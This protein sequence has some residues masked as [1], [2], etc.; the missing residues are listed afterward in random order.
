[1]CKGDPSTEELVPF[2]AS[3]IKQLV[4]KNYLVGGRQQPELSGRRQLADFANQVTGTC[5]VSGYCVLTP[6]Q[7][8][9]RRGFCPANHTAQEVLLWE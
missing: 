1:M 2:S 5:Q 4:Q 3:R 9:S 8:W 7:K 6:H